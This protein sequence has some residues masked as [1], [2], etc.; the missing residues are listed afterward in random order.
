MSGLSSQPWLHQH[1]TEV[2]VP[3]SHPQ[4]WSEQSTWSAQKRQAAQASHVPGS[5]VRTTIIRGKPLVDALLS[6]AAGRPADK[7]RGEVMD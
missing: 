7:T 2:A 4:H 6:Q 3:A 5:H 1:S